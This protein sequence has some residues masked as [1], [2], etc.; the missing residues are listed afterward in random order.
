MKLNLYIGTIIVLFSTNV[1]S[2]T[3]VTNQPASH[4]DGQFIDR[5]DGTL[6]DV[7]TNLLWSKCNVGESYNIGTGKCD[8]TA[9]E[10]AK[11]EDALIATQDSSLTT[12]AGQSNFRLPNIKELSSIVDYRC[13][14]PAINLTYFPTTTNEPYWTN[15]PDA[16]Q[17]NVNYDGLVIDFGEALEVIT[18]PSDLPSPL[19]RLVKEFN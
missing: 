12:I 18:A 3:C 4:Q 15:T 10:Y 2:Q 9:T 5:N 17:I 14:M 16:K 8:G 7:S 1:L 19:I 13:T 11:W 6:L